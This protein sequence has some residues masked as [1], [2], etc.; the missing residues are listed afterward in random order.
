[1]SVRTT[2]V[3]EAAQAALQGRYEYWRSLLNTELGVGGAETPPYALPA[4]EDTQVRIRAQM[5]AGSGAGTHLRLVPATGAARY[6]DSQGRV[7]IRGAFELGAYLVADD[8][9][10][11]PAGDAEGQLV[12]AS[13]DV[14]EAA[15][16]ALMELRA[17]PRLVGQAGVYQVESAVLDHNLYLVKK[18]V[19][20][21]IVVR[22]SVNYYQRGDV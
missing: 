11:D 12:R 15:R 10:L 8:A 6:T 16:R 4:L 20:T 3:L 2:K 5:D 17:T 7:V 9:Q 22:A 14:M 1:M 19:I 18:G 13:Y 21:G